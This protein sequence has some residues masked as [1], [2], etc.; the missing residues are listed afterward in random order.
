MPSLLTLP[1]TSQA[2][3]SLGDAQYGA[4]VDCW[5]LG[6]IVY[7]LLYGEPPCL[8]NVHTPV[9][10]FCYSRLLFTHRC[11]T[12]SFAGEPPY[13]SNDDNQQ[14][15]LILRHELQFPPEVFDQ[16]RCEHEV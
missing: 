16:V 10:T 5:A 8:S 6:C 1:R 9:H 3:D 13:L 4:A 7:E 11:F 15:A 14:M 2:G 12:P